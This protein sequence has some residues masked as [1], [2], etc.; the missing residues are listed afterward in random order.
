MKNIDASQQKILDLYSNY[1]LRNNKKP[2]NVFTFCEDNQISETDFYFYYANFVQ[3]EGDYLRFFMNQ[4]L[5]L[6]SEEENYQAQSAKHKLLSFYYTFFEQLTMN[7]SLIIYLLDSEKNDLQNIKKM[8]P[9]KKEFQIF[10]RS[11][12]ISEPM[13]D[14]TS[15]SMAKIERFKNKGIEELYWGHFMA[16]LKFWL[17]D[18]SSNFE[19]TDIFIE[20]SV[21]TSFE[22]LDVK[23]LKKL[24][25]LGKFLFN[26]KVKNNG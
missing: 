12:E 15:E 17:D 19:K 6:I 26:E 16:T 9:L 7:R 2:L 10:V 13:M 1:A 8:W 25:D 5:V 20:K 22:L 18:T 21:D 24:V 23:P 14:N 11:L 3:L 4:A